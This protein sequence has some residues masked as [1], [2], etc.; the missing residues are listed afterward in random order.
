M[1]EKKTFREH[2][3]PSDKKENFYSD[4][5]INVDPAQV[6]RYEFR[7]YTSKEITEA[8]EIAEEE[9]EMA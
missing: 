5:Y 9:L 7:L 4:S 2:F 8:E 3:L 6:D 1:R